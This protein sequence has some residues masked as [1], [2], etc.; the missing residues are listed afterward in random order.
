MSFN[1]SS[2]IFKVIVASFLF[3][4]L[5]LLNY[6]ILNKIISDATQLTVLKHSITTWIMFLLLIVICFCDN[7]NKKTVF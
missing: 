7:D 1:V 2:I 3:G 5:F 4:T 6:I